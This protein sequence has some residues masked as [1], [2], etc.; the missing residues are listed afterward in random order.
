MENFDLV[1][2]GQLV[3]E[4]E[5][6][7]GEIGVNNGK[8]SSIVKETNLLKGSR[9]LD[10]GKSFVFPGMIDVHVHCFSNPN[11][12]FITTSSS[13]AAGGVTT[14][15]DMPYDLPNPIN[16]VDQFERKVKQLEAE[17]VVDICLWGTISKTGGTDQINK[18]AEA[19][20][21]AFKMSTFE[22]DAYRFPRIP[23]PEIMRA[24]ELIRETGLVAAF[25]SEND[26]IIVDL[27]DQYI[28]ENKVYPRAHMET[29]PPVTE[30]SAVLKLLEFAYWTGVKLHI[31][32]V[33][34]PR[35][36]DLINL[37]K[38][39][40]V[41]VTSETCYPYLLL[42]VNDLEKHG[43]R[44]KNNPPLR[45]PEDVEGLWKHLQA[46]D[47]EL[48]SSDHAP[49]GLEHKEKGQDNIFLAASGLPGLE[50]IAPLMFDSGVAKGRLTP[51]EFAKLMAQHPA[52]VFQI[53]GKGKI[54]V[55]YDA[56]F[57]VIDPEQSWIVDE[58]KFRSHSKLTPF[59]GCKVQGKVVQTIVRG[60]TVY[61]GNEV[62]VK[63]GFGS[64]VPG[65]AAKKVVAGR[66]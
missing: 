38:K 58:T 45:N 3:L 62:T 49:W 17:A 64:F 51:V 30:T 42:D 2:R 15:L 16:N 39:Q 43:P 13:A 18:L 12:G 40:G 55:Q 31:V 61:D 65:K 26:E 56:D 9:V 57:T 63:P 23:D 34:H 25:H 7:I 21:V 60:T 19:G 47:I 11:E 52:E 44:A 20:A 32:H 46:G 66:K 8:I 33:S 10:F 4:D 5:V 37:F 27:I 14:F 53:P 50:I 6:V 41:Q 36:I 1:V 22:T 35:T 59:H 54:A 29:R 28:E 48:I 24:M